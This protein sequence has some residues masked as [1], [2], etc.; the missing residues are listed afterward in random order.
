MTNAEKTNALLELKR[1]AES[2]SR[3]IDEFKPPNE[4]KLAFAYKIATVL[5]K[6]LT[7]NTED[8]RNEENYGR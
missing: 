5:Y 3:H 2:S 8:N 6:I 7:I 4:V 1:V